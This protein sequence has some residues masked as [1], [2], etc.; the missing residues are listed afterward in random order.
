MEEIF[1][2]CPGCGSEMEHGFIEELEKNREGILARH[3]NLSWYPDENRGKLFVKGGVNLNLTG[4]GY[5]CKKCNVVYGEF[6]AFDPR[7]GW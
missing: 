3:S 5:Y 4:G 6:E 7:K 2:K 1:M